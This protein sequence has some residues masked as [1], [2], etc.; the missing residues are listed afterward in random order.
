MPLINR[1][2]KDAVGIVKNFDSKKTKIQKKTSFLFPDLQETTDATVLVE[3]IKIQLSIC[4]PT[5]AKV[6]LRRKIL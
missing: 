6:R 5:D 1:K 3:F 4:Y 2:F